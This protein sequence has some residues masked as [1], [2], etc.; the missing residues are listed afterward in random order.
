MDST[1]RFPNAST[2]LAV[3]A[4]LLAVLA[5]AAPAFAVD[6]RN[7]T[8]LSTMNP[9]PADFGWPWSYSTVWAYTHTDG[10][11]YAL[12]ASIS[13][14]SV[15]RLTDPTHPVESAVINLRDSGWHEMRQYGTH[16]YIVTEVENGVPAVEG[17]AVI[18]MSDPEH[19]RKVPYASTIQWA[20]SLEIDTARGYLYANGTDR[21]VVV[22][23][24][25]N[26]DSPVEIA[27]YPFYA[28]DTHLRGNLAYCS[29]I[30]DGEETVLDV[31]NPAAPVELATF[32]SPLK[33]THS[34]WTTEDGRYLYVTDETIQKNL[35]V[36]DISNLNSVQLLW[37]HERFPLDV[38][39]HPRI[40]GTTA[41]ISHYTRGV[42]L[43]D[44]RNGGWPVEYGY[45]DESDYPYFGFHGAWEV[46]PFFPSG[47]F[48]VSD[49]QT[50][51]WVFRASG[52]YGVVR[53]TVRDAVTLQPIEGATIAATGTSAPSQSDGRYGIAPTPGRVTLTTT[54]FG[55]VTDTRTITLNAG[56]DRTID[57]NLVKHP[58]TIRGRVTDAATSAGLGS[59]EMDLLG[60]P[61]HIVTDGTGA[62]TFPAVPPGSYTLRCARPGY[63]T[64]SASLTVQQSKETAANFAV[65]AASFYDDFESD[66]GWVVGSR[67]DDATYG[68]WARGAPYEW[69]YCTT[70]EPYDIQPGADHSPDPGTI[71]F[72]TGPRQTDYYVIGRTT[73]TSPALNLAGMS[74][75]RIAYWRW[76]T[77]QVG[78]ITADDPFQTQISG[79]GGQSWTT[80]SNDYFPPRGW[81]YVEFR[82]RDFVP[83]GN[84]VQVRFIV[85]ENG[86]FS[87]NEATV[88]DVALFNG[89]GGGGLAAPML[90]V[91]E[92]AAAVF[93]RVGP[94]PARGAVRMGVSLAHETAVKAS[95]YDAQGR[96]VAVV[97]DGAMSAGPHTLEWNGRVRS[98]EAAAA[99]VYFMEVKAGTAVKRDKFVM[100]R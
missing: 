64:R 76:F 36:Y 3:F 60:T 61:L 7:V 41:F 20:H 42:R 85:D 24:L 15:I 11:E 38:V 59:A 33:S 1:T 19:P 10:R 88:D 83:T 51:L 18:D 50:G 54:A 81:Q 22:Y 90:S 98:G 79:N 21:G 94:S 30:Y 23:T 96:L 40:R 45:Y 16:V 44:V 35:A 84:T 65:P 13:G 100:L 39:H 82:V 97:T 26:P 71:A 68:I 2:G 34:A 75:P 32:Q 57:V 74:D 63:A 93:G 53:G 29:R 70:D 58:G 72:V 27:T 46:C 66:R 25:A 55:Y 5:L 8:L 56:D 31:T 91:D 87:I 6:G 67:D 48:C 9:H 80:V 92:G 4:I 73:L 43:W 89:A 37:R 14:V 17:L 78:A 86:E 95:I 69:C 52:S 47:I 77:N 99:G 62:F 12:L 49:M 28:H